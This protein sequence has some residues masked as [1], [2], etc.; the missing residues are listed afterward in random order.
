MDDSLPKLK[1]KHVSALAAEQSFQKGE[2]YFQ[3]GAIAHPVRQGNKLYAECAGTFLY[4][5]SATLNAQ[6][7]ESSSCTCP[8][9]W[10]GICKH[11][12]ALLLTYIHKP[13]RFQVIQPLAELLAECSRDDLLDLIKQMIQRYPDLI[14]IVDAPAVPTTGQLL[15]L[16]NYQRQV[17][18]VFQADEMHTMASGLEALTSHGDRLHQQKD[19]VYAGEIYQ[20]LLAT[21]NEQ[22]DYSALDID[23]NGEVGCVIQSIAEGL[24]SCLEQAEHLDTDQRRCWI[25][26]LFRAVLKDIELG[27][28]DYAYPAGDA[29]VQH[30]TDTDWGW[31][32]PQIREQIQTAGKNACSDW[33]RQ[34]LVGLLTERAAQ[35]GNNQSA[36]AII[37]ELGTPQQQ[38]FFHLEHGNLEEAVAIAQSHFKSWP[39]L[40]T[41]F[42]DGLLATDAPDLALAFVQDCVG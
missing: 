31:L 22:Y 5:V 33:E 2:R 4:R 35:Q 24:S 39:G 26:T 17:E 13:E 18:R 38:A 30:T 19:W 27:G 41:Q 37:L 40:V 34:R 8:Y 16:D 32:E 23:Y 10:G 36:E 42:A 3:N 25:E 9:D 12:V 29:I 20:L 28:I 11:E 6:G 7:I 21:A 1:P 15:D 14:D